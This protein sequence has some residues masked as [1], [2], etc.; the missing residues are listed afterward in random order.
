MSDSLQPHGLQHA[1]LPCPSPTPCHTKQE[2][3]KNIGWG[4]ATDGLGVGPNVYKELCICV[5]LDGHEFEQ[6]P[7]V[8]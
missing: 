4:I 1:G 8:G 6:A 2:L 5:Q 3:K 7:A